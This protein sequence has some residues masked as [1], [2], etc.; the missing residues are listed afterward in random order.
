MQK[1]ILLFAIIISGV[2][3]PAIGDSAYRIHLRSGGRISTSQYWEEKQELKFYAGGGVVGIEKGMVKRIEKCTIDGTKV[4][5]SQIPPEK[6]R[7]EAEPKVEKDLS[8][9]KLPAQ[10]D[11]K[12]YRDKMAKLKADLNKT[13]SRIRKATA[14]N[15]AAAKDEAMADNRRISAEMWELTDEL[16][17]KNN[18][19]LPADWWEG[20][21]RE[22]ATIQ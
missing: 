18:G 1:Y 22:E 2:M 16:K 9:P 6:T 3:H 21:G 17:E 5:A 12:A 20:I 14:N 19:K 10:F 15:D 13:L 11:L 4:Y 8:P 7:A